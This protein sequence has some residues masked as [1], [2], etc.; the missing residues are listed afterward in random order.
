[1]NTCS[2]ISELQ[3]IL[4]PFRNTNRKIVLVPTMGFLHEGHLQLIRRAKELGDVAV[5]SIFVN[6]TQ[7]SP[8]EDFSQYPRDIER[9]KQLAEK[10]GC[11]VLFI[12]SNEELYP[13]GYLTYVDVYEMNSV[14]EGKFRPTHFRGVTTI[15]LKLFNIV[16]PKVALFGQKDAQQS[17]IVKKMVRDLHLPV[18]IEILPTVREHDGLAM[19]SRNVY[20]TEQQR[21]DASVLFQ[22]LQFAKK[23]IETGETNSHR[24]INEMKTMIEAKKDTAIDYIEI[25]DSETLQHLSTIEK[26]KTILIPLAVR[27]GATRLIDNI[28]ITT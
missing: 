16:Q 27:F 20:L 7:F 12:P 15:V 13:N 1:M 28:L 8:T 19:S 24:I 11:D 17:V 2:S 3:T 22:S 10:A 14:L 23:K 4:L 26:G 6:P 18:T 5:V 21:S 9:D 25:V